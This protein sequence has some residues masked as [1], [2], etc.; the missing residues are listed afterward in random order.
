MTNQDRLQQNNAKIEKIQES[1]KNKVA[2]SGEIELTENNIIYD[3]SKYANAKTNIYVPDLSETTATENDVVSGKL[4]YNASGEKVTGTYIDMMQQ[5]VNASAS[6]LLYNT[7]ITNAD[8]LSNLVLPSSISSMFAYSKLS[9]APQL[10]TSNCTNF[11]AMFSY[12]GSLT[13]VPDY[14]TSNGTN[15]A[16]MFSNSSLETAPNID[17]SNAEDMDGMFSYCRKI[18]TIPA[19]NVSKAT[20][21][22]NMFNT[23]TLLENVP[24]LNSI[25]CVKFASMFS[26]CLNLKTVAGLD[27]RSASTLTANTR[28]MFSSCAKLENLI[29]KNI[30]INLQIASGTS[31]G[32]L[33]NLHSLL[34]TIKEL[35]INTSGTKTLTIGTTNIAKLEDVYVKLIDITDEMRAEDEYIDNKAPFVQCESTDEGAMLVTEYVTTIKNWQLA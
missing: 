27:L 5:R 10:D 1:L 30:K 34:N 17:T 12:C 2:T 20:T 23:C 32:H 28:N 9:Q 7:Y 3:V 13:T 4:F 8:Y 18:T 25:N 26:S 31:Y 24:E 22:A 6:N 14:N 33:L 11:S 15:F 35:H 29:L 21:L 19:Y 16:G